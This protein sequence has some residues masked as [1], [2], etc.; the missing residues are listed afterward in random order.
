MI[1]INPIQGLMI[2]ALCGLSQAAGVLIGKRLGSGDYDRAYGE[3][4][5]LVWYG[6]VG[7]L[8]LSMVIVVT[9]GWYVEIYQVEEAV[10]VLTERILLAY[11]AIAPFKV[12]NM[13]L[14]GGVLRSGGR[15][16]FVMGIDLMGIWC[17]GVPLGFL[18]AFW[19]ELPIYWVYLLLS[20]EECLRFG[21]GAA[22]FRGRKWMRS[23]A[24]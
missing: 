22:V 7:A 19:L 16:E 15:T 17:F 23:L 10:K 8:I 13:I 21:I 24:G 11:A 5:K 6:L 1:L 14:G 4:R 20:L 9:R 12:G 2:G 18:A 3:S